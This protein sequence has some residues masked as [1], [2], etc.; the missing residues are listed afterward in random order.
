M[1]GSEV[2][3]SEVEGSEVEGS[4]LVLR[5]PRFPP[6]SP[7]APKGITTTGTAPIRVD[8]LAAMV[9]WHCVV[10]KI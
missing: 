8:V 5:V 10:T 6:T 7:D 3:G 1:E 2:E 4:E 9:G